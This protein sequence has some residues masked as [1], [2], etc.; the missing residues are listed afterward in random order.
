MEIAMIWAFLMGVGLYF[1]IAAPSEEVLVAKQRLADINSRV[2]QKGDSFKE[3]VWL[4]FLKSTKQRLVFITPT[5]LKNTWADRLSKAGKPIELGTYIWY[6]VLLAFLLGSVPFILDSPKMLL[7]ILLFGIG[8][9][10]P[11]VWLKTKTNERQLQLSRSL[12]DVLDVLTVSVEAGL[13]FDGAVQKVS[14]KFS[15]PVAE[16]FGTYLKEVRLG[17]KR[18]DALRNLSL[19]ADIP[20]MRSFTA[21]IIQADALG[22]SISKVLR[23]QSDQLRVKRRQAAEEKAM[24]LPIK[25][26]FPLVL[27]IFPTI[28]IVL[29]GPVLIQIMQMQ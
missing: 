10:L 11:D 7:A 5:R 17:K 3:R 4:P 9:Y 16:E 12:P 13:G 8:L 19:R 25:M 2:E 28:F 6:K 24:K 21:A 1:V 14:E 15:G 26:L 29:L 27:F 18:A 20:E 23:V 22:V